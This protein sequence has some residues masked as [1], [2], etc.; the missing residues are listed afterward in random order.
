MASSPKSKGHLHMFNEPYPAEMFRCALIERDTQVWESV[1]RTYH[2]MVLTWLHHHPESKAVCHL[3]SED[4][5]VSQAFERLWQATAANQA[6]A[7][8]TVAALLE[9][10]QISL[11]SVLIDAQRI[12]LLKHEVSIP[13]VW[14]VKNFENCSGLWETIGLLLPDVREHR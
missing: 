5:L 14:P 13:G 9:Y 11:N 6:L 3:V 2:K 7:H 1:R 12:S 4:Y 8:N 10:L